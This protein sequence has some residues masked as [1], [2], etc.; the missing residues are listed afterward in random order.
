VKEG[1]CR[2]RKALWSLRRAEVVPMQ[3]QAGESKH[4]RCTQRLVASW[5]GKTRAI[6]IALTAKHEFEH[7]WL[8]VD[9]LHYAR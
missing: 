5:G 6:G 2:G 4:D 7:E 3:V 9:L 1:S 8:K